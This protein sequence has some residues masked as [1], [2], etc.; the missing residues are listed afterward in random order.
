MRS[1]QTSIND[2]VAASPG[3]N[4]AGGA[5]SAGTD[6]LWPN[7]KASEVLIPEPPP[8]AAATPETPD[9]RGVCGYLKFNAL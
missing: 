7:Q 1:F 2:P 9:L 3:L 8:A 4:S 5:S 6:H